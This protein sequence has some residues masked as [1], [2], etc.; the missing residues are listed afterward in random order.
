MIS[1][2]E[3]PHTLVIGLMNNVYRVCRYYPS[4]DTSW[5]IS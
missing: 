3:K 4:S 1:E 2:G 5:N